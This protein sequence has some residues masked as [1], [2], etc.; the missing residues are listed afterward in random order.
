MPFSN[1]KLKILRALQQKKHRQLTGRFLVEG[2]RLC[3]EAMAGPAV[4]VE[5][6]ISAAPVSQRL[7]RLVRQMETRGVPVHQVAL[8]DLEKLCETE[9]PQGVVAVIEKPKQGL[10]NWSEFDEPLVVAIDQLQDP[11]NLGTLLRTADWFG[12][13]SV[14]IGQNSVEL[15]NPKVVR[16]TMGSIFRLRCYEGLEMTDSLRQLRHR[17]YRVTAAVVE[18][19]APISPQKCKTVLL[20]GS[21]AE[22]LSMELLALADSCFTIPRLGSGESLNAAIA[23][24]I[25]LNELTKR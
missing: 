16:S 3:E 15:Y 6:L 25:A 7:I 2:L 8:Q 24:G 10:P 9:T 19:G 14:L 11:G 20:I 22:G 23:A 5:V 18:N 17:G 13:K 4:I 1:K 21:E 12:V